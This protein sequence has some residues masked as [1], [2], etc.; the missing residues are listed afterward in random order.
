MQSGL[1]PSKVGPQG[2]GPGRH[3]G[4]SQVLGPAIERVDITVIHH[5]VVVLV[6]PVGE[7]DEIRHR[8]VDAEEPGGGAIVE[9]G[10]SRKDEQD[11]LN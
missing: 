9:G 5:H 11:E 6:A 2:C 4:E 3:V 8:I 7:A 10:P 1:Q